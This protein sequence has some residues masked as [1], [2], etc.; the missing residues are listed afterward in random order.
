MA[1]NA[2]IAFTTSTTHTVEAGPDLILSAPAAIS[3][4]S[5]EGTALT[6]QWSASSPNVSFSPSVNILNPQ[7]NQ[8][9]MVHT[10]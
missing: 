2:P 3:A 9:Q 8:A 1:S 6:Y 5:S 4:A 7:F 10:R